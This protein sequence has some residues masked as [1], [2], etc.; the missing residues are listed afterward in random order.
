MDREMARRMDGHLLR[1]DPR[2]LRGL[3]GKTLFLLHVE[4]KVVE[5][6][7]KKMVPNFD[8]PCQW[9]RRLD[10]LERRRDA[11]RLICLQF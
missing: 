11:A 10:G 7:E 1:F 5:L 4:K 9:R 3:C 6:I 2:P 8:G